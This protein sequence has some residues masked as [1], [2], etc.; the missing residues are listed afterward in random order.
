MIDPSEKYLKKLH[1]PVRHDFCRAIYLTFLQVL[2]KSEVV[3]FYTKCPLSLN[4]SELPTVELFQLLWK[5][6]ALVSMKWLYDMGENLESF[7]TVRGVDAYEFMRMALWRNN[8]G[9]HMPG[10]VILSWFSPKIGRLFKSFDGHDV[11]VSMF[12]HFTENFLPF[13][14][15]RR[16]K[17][18]SDGLQVRSYLAYIIDKDFEVIHEWNF[19][20]IAGMQIKYS[21]LIFGLPPFERVEMLSDTRP[22]GKVLW[23]SD[24]VRK[25]SEIFLNNRRV[26]VAI[27]FTEF[28]SKH[29]L[30][31]SPYKVPDREVYEAVEDCHCEIRNR[32]VVH[33]GCVY[34]APLFLHLV[35]HKKGKSSRSDFLDPMLKDAN[36]DP[37]APSWEIEEKH[38]DLINS[39]QGK[40]QIEYLISDENIIINGKQFVKGL[41]AKILKSLILYH[42]ESGK[43]EFEYWELKKTHEIAGGLKPQNFEIRFYRLMEKLERED[44]GIKIEKIARGKFLFKIRSPIT[45]VEKQSYEGP[46][47][48]V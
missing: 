20:L 34:G 22:L 18:T 28:C 6:K 33:S 36:D 39:L 35:I 3:T 37:T 42:L 9:S 23:K 21:P 26:A 41:A 7:L 4:G 5:D 31:L 15:H 12:Q 8:Q 1:V 45:F 44:H 30:D 43:T 29:D 11:I 19:E 27:G 2:P 10:K 24:L 46:S 17:K 25:G 38:F 14:L 40:T 48:L 47:P 16:L 32:I 13:H